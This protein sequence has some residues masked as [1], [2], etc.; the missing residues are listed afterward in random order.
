MRKL[1]LLFLMTWFGASF[2][3]NDSEKLGLARQ[4][5]ERQFNNNE[6]TP[7]KSDA[8][9]E[10]SFNKILR[11]TQRKLVLM[12]LRQFPKLSD[13][14]VS[15]IVNPSIQAVYRNFQG[16]L[17]RWAPEIEQRN[18]DAYMLHF[19]AD[20]LREILNRHPDIVS[21]KH[22]QFTNTVLPAFVSVDQMKWH[23]IGEELARSLQ[24]IQRE[25]ATKS[26]EKTAQ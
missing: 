5:V 23:N 22:K 9:I 19:S 10:Q 11:D 2:A 20:E 14:E 17:K 18:I 26:S 13:A 4:I 16:G 6:S 7:Q 25:L 1:I 15:A 8:E 24:Q 12:N 3:Q 21:E